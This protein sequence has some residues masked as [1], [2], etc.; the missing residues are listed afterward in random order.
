MAFEI[1]GFAVHYGLSASSVPALAEVVFYRRGAKAQRK[2]KHWKGRRIRLSGDVLLR[3]FAPLRFMFS[4]MRVRR[5]SDIV[6]LFVGFATQHFRR[7]KN[8]KYQLQTMCCRHLSA[9]GT[10]V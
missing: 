3:A 8:N 7:R 5:L 1:V 6:I 4:D 2:A 9:P 10:V